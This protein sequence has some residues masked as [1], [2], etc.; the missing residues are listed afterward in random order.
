MN[1]PAR[2][3]L[4]IAQ[5]AR[6]IGLQMLEERGCSPTDS[7]FQPNRPLGSFGARITL[8]ARMGQS[9]PIW[10]P[11]ERILQE[12]VVVAGTPL[13]P[14]LRDYLL[15]ITIL[16]GLLEA[17]AQQLRPQPPQVVKGFTGLS[18]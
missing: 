14:A 17:A 12:K 6:T 3:Q 1:Q 2:H 4:Q 8:A 13:D 11:L 7:F 18:Q 15:L 10:P 16:V 5:T 9:N